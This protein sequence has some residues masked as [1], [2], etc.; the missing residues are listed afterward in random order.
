MRDSS[1]AGV[2]VARSHDTYA[3]PRRWPDLRHPRRAESKC[4]ETESEKKFAVGHAVERTASRHRQIFIGDALVQLVQRVKEH[5]FKTVLH[6]IGKV[7]VTLRYFRVRL[8]RRPKELFHFVAE[9]PRQAYCSVGQY[10]HSL[11]ASK[12]LEVAHV[13]LEAAVLQRGNLADFIDV[14]VFPVGGETHDFALITIFFVADEIADHGVKTAERMGKENAFEDVDV[15]ALA[16]RHHGGNEVAGTVIAEACRFFPGRAVVRTRNV[17]EVMLDMVLLKV[18][19]FRIEFERLRKQQAHVP[20]GFLALPHFDEV[21]DFGRIRQ[22]VLNF[23]A[24][25]ASLSWPTATC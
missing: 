22:C 14:G 25:C 17:R 2:A 23:F 5:F 7:H 11:I 15:I 10:L 6:G 12:R 8:A 20:H 4:G 1:A 9:M 21:Q 24:R 16:T 3:A 19:H 13:E 18:Q